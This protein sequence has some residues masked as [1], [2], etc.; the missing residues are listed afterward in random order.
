[1]AIDSEFIFV[2]IYGIPMPVNYISSSAESPHPR[3]A[4]P[5]ARCEVEVC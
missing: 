1:M 5:W 4:V 2:F 3:I